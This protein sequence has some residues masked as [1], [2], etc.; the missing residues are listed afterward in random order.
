[1]KLTLLC[2]IL[3]ALPLCCFSQTQSTSNHT[4]EFWQNV[5]ANDFEQPQGTSL[6]SLLWE[7]SGFLASSNPEF[8]DNIAYSVLVQW[9]YVKQIVSPQMLRKLIAKW[10]SNLKHS[11]GEKGT[12]SVLVRSFSA[13]MLSVMA[14]Y[15]NKEPFLREDE[16]DQL[17]QN[18][19]I[20]LKD[21]QDVRGFDSKLG[22]LHSVAHTADLLK[23]LS[24]SRNIDAKQQSTILLA[25]ANKLNQI[26]QPLVQGEN[27]RLA[28]VAVAIMAQEDADTTAFRTFLNKLKPT[29]LSKPITK[30]KLAVLQN[31]KH[32]V[33]ALYSVL[34]VTARDNDSLK[35]AIAMMLELLKATV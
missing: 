17:L 3:A 33:M 24:R 23:F 15:D 21:E 31:H 32:F 4:L 13:L 18:A 9:I 12:N 35:P 2:A 26:K 10:S 20:Y 29:P 22:W 27:E 7:L 30:Q 8:R 19:L 6:D 28:R 5:M 16:V 11:I 1:M 34:V 14:A 25:I